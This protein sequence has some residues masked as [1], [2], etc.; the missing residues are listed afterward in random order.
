MLEVQELLKK[1]NRNVARYKDLPNSHVYISYSN[2]SPQYYLKSADKPRHYVKRKDVRNIAKYAQRDYENE[3]NKQLVFLE[4]KLTHFLDWYDIEKIKEYDN[5]SPA[6]R[7]LIKPLVPSDYLFAEEW[8]KEHP[9][10]RN[11]YPEEGM[12][13]TNRGEMVR[14]KSEKIIADAL[15]KYGVPYQYEPVLEL[16]YN[17]VYPDFAVLNLRTRKTLYW[18][19]LGIVSDMEYATKNF[20]KIQNYEKNGYLLGKDL[21]TTMESTDLPIDIKLV[22]QKIR[23]FLL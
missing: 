23:E 17:T 20:I 9:G 3:M 18:E 5:Y 6:K 12:Y 7:A 16:G 4:K 14:S 2:G 8:Y 19:H 1:S 11:S 21:I 13:Q 22:E 10:Q 15:A